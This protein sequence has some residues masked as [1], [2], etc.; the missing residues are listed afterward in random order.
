M[1]PQGAAWILPVLSLPHI[2][3]A[4]LWFYPD[5]WVA[6]TRSLLGTKAKGMKRTAVGGAACSHMAT[7]AH[8]IKVIQTA[9]MLAW[10]YTYAPS[11]LSLSALQAQ[12]LAQLGLGIGLVLC[13]QIF[14]VGIYTA[15][16]QNG[17]YYGNKFG[18][19][20]GPWCTG[21]PFNV[22]GP[23]GRHPQ[24]F[25]VLLTIAG[26]TVLAW[27]PEMVEAGGVVVSLTWCSYYVVTSIIEQTENTERK[28][29]D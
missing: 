6:I 17:V 13:G 22:P 8:V 2:F 12:P 1:V 23:I 7:A 29:E 14:N 21:F 5:A 9:G 19:P 27:C 11:A 4:W 3:Y 26:L 16:G 18:A 25:G 10:Y 20:L 28:I 15:I 24:Y